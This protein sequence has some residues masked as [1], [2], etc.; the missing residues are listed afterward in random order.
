MQSRE[1]KTAVCRLQELD[2]PGSRGFS[3]GEGEWPFR[4]FVVRRGAEVY[5]YRNRCPHQGH[6][7]NWKPHAFL[8]RDGAY[9]LC[10]SHGALFE[11]ANGL[12]V[13]GPCPGKTLGRLAVAIEDGVVVVGV[14]RSALHSA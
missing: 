8:T 3:V 13:A 12:C 9:I 7:L 2:D 4:G 14:P 6:A 1:V 11:P 10:A 5:A